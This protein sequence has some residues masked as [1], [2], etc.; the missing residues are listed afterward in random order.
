MEPTL[1]SILIKTAVTHTV[2]YVIVGMLAY[3][4]FNYLRLFAET[5]L[6]HLMRN[7]LLVISKG[8]R[9]INRF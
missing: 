5:G 6:Q 1:T 4:L 7:Q 2:S 8:I 9:Q 3:K